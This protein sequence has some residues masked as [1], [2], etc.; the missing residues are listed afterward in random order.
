MKTFF[1]PQKTFF[2]NS[3]CILLESLRHVC[4]GDTECLDCREWVLEVERIRVVI[5][6]TELHHLKR[7]I[8]GELNEYGYEEKM[9]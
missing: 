2:S 4:Q 7:S 9:Q 3:C 5:D 6:P 8:P 1:F